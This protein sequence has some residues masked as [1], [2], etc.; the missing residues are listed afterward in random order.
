MSITKGKHYQKHSN[1]TI[2]RRL[3][4]VNKERKGNTRISILLRAKL[5]Y[6]YKSSFFR[7]RIVICSFSKRKSLHVQV[8]TDHWGTLQRR[9]GVI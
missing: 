2:Y 1:G 9:R 4:L 5:V 6:Q 3:V 8:Q 7:S